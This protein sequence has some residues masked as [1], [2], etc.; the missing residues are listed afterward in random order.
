M[1]Q[2]L[3]GSK[4]TAVITENWHLILNTNLHWCILIFGGT[5]LKTFKNIWYCWTPIR[6]SLTL[7]V[8][9]QLVVRLMQ[10]Y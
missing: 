1:V 8:V 10:V 3:T 7:R 2:W 6:K 4:S 9:V 5:T